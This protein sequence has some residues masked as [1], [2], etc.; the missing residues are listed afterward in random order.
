MAN[1]KSSKEG[2][3]CHHLVISYSMQKTY[4]F[5][6]SLKWISVSEFIDWWFFVCR[7]CNNV[8]PVSLISNCDG[9]FCGNVLCKGEKKERINKYTT[10]TDVA[11]R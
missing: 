10:K 6:I 2:N 7:D 5:Q 8:H 11:I 4:R 1:Y 9:N 3:E